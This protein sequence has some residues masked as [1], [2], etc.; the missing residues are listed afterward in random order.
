MWVKKE[1][2]IA[3]W[4]DADQAIMLF[5]SLVHIFMYS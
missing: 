3:L 4:F 5:H 1:Q 2:E